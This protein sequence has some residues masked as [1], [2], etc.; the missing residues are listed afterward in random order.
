VFLEEVSHGRKRDILLGTWNVRSLYRAGSLTA[1]AREFRGPHSVRFPYAE[2]AVIPIPPTPFCGR[3]PSGYPPPLH[4]RFR[5][6]FPLSS[7]M[8]LL[9]FHVTVVL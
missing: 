3:T 7:S 2:M 1:E 8:F 4:H 9:Q 6:A 5:R